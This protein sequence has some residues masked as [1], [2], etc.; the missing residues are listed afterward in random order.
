MSNT[1]DNVACAF[2]WDQGT[3]EDSSS[4]STGLGE[5]LNALQAVQALLWRN[6]DFTS[7]PSNST[8]S[9]NATTSGSPSGVSGSPENT[10]AGSTVAASVT[11]VLTVAFAAALS[12]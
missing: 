6:A 9:T 3:V 2:G 11:L 10:G 8:A 7:S 12:C 5:L 4:T 1:K